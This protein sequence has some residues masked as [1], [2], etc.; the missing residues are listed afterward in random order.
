MRKFFAF[1]VFALTLAVVPAIAVQS[2]APPVPSPEDIDMI[3]GP[4]GCCGLIPG[5]ACCKPDPP[6]P[7]KPPSFN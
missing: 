5:M 2:P 6:G 4:G 1:V 3:G 7:P